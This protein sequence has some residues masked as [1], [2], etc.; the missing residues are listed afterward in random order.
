MEAKAYV[1]DTEQGHL[2]REYELPDGPEPA[3]VELDQWSLFIAG[4]SLSI[5]NRNNGF[6]HQLLD[7]SVEEGSEQ[8]LW[9][10]RWCAVHH[11][12][13]GRHLIVVGDANEVIWIRNYRDV[14]SDTNNEIDRQRLA[15]N[16]V[17][18]R[19][20]ESPSEITIDNVCVENDRG[21]SVE[22]QRQEIYMLT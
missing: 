8:A 15:S 9:S 22:N 5:I 12:L 3:Y 1:F 20:E 18:L 7:V 21:Q 11:S 14:L 2:S 17:V 4:S 6:V 10:T 16:T 13:D 19:L